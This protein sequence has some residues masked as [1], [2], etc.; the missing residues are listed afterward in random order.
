[1]HRSWLCSVII[2]CEDLEAGVAFWREAL[3]VRVAGR[4]APFVWLETPPGSLLIG[5]GIQAVPEPKT[6]K[7]RVHLDFMTDDLEAEVRRLGALG[8]TR[9][10]C[11]GEALWVMLDPCGNEL[12]VIQ[13][14]SGE[15][16][17]GARTWG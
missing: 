2:D 6:C 7:T 5:V 1:M 9:Q 12:C 16:P 3:R 4:S 10:E 8:A 17:Q 13:Q 11:V 14:E 15:S